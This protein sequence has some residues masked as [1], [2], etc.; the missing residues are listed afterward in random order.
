MLY[1]VE[2]FICLLI[3]L[4]RRY[5]LLHITQD[6]VQVLIVGLGQ[7]KSKKDELGEVHTKA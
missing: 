4:H 1:L 3:N 2:F 6:H 5:R 7:T